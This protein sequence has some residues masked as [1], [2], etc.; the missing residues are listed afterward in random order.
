M[1]LTWKQYKVSLQFL[2]TN[3]HVKTNNQ[4]TKRKPA[5]PNKP[6]KPSKGVGTKTWSVNLVAVTHKELFGEIVQV[7]EGQLARVI[8]LAYAQVDNSVVNDVARRNDDVS[9]DDKVHWMSVLSFIPFD[10]N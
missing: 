8:A 2:C 9:D 7:C 5:P 3:R 6:T 4:T 1:Q 10:D